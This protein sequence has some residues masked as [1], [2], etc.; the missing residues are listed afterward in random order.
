MSRITF[1]QLSAAHQRIDDEIAQLSTEE[2][3][4]NIY[5]LT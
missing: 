2:G 5:E 1:Y 4:Q 3:P